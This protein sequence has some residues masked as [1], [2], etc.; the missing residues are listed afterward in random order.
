MLAAKRRRAIYELFISTGA[1]TLWIATMRV[2]DFY[3]IGGRAWVRIATYGLEHTE[4]ID[5]LLETHLDEYV[6]AA[7]IAHDPASP[8]FRYLRGDKISRLGKTP[9]HVSVAIR[10]QAMLSKGQAPDPDTLE[11]PS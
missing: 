8:L 7:R 6:A 11:A 2:Q 10:Q 9:R 3:R 4:P 1:T 5:R